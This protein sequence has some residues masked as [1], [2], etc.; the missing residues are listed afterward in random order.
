MIK[1]AWSRARGLLTHLV[2][3]KSKKVQIQIK[4]IA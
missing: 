1:V 3:M 4:Q 2:G